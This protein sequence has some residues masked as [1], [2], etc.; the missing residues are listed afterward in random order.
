G[1]GVSAASVGM[2]YAL[3]TERRTSLDF[4]F[5]AS[6]PGDGPPGG[7]TVTAHGDGRVRADGPGWRPPGGHG[8]VQRAG[9]RRTIDLASGVRWERLPPAPP[10]P[11][12]SLAL[13]SHPPPHPPNP[14]PA[15][16]AR[17]ARPAT[18]TAGPPGARCTPVSG[19][20]PSSWGRAPRSRSIQR[21]RTCTGTPPPATCTRSGRSCMLSPA[22]PEGCAGP[23]GRPPRNPPMAGQPPATWSRRLRPCWPAGAPPPPPPPR[24]RAPPP[25]RPP[26]LRRAR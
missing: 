1:R 4:L 8:I 15:R 11:L 26:A 16:A 12:D 22:A 13:I 5:G 9:T 19:S 20:T 17:G 24:P 14:P 21:C 3:A 2:V 18:S 10:P 23:G 25:P 6:P 7:V